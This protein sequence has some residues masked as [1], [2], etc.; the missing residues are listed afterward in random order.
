VLMSL[1]FLPL[2]V[3]LLGIEAYGVLGFFFSLLALLSVLDAGL[4]TTLNRGLAQSLTVPGASQEARDLVRTLE[5]VY[6]SVGLLIALLLI[7]VAPFIAGYWLNSREVSVETVTQA[8]VMMGVVTALQWPS[9]LYTGGLL[10]L[11]RQVL[12]NVITGSVVVL[13]NVGAVLILWL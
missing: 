6:W 8:G 11:Q 12:L 7:A 4:S 3:K 5:V 2:Y 10:G 9:S 13:Q 1:V